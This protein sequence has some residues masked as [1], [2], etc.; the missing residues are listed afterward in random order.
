MNKNY[1]Y[2]NKTANQWYAKMADHYGGPKGSLV[3]FYS[4]VTIFQ[5]KLKHVFT[6][7]KTQEVDFE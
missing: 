7:A 2:G 3:G 5:N 1:W 6:K 4:G